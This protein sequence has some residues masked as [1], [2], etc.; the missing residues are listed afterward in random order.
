MKY[1]LEIWYGE[2]EVGQEIVLSMC[3]GDNL[4][5]AIRQANKL[6]GI[7]LAGHGG[8]IVVSKKTKNEQGFIDS[9]ELLEL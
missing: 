5:S 3:F 1:Y 6:A 9:E 7:M 8:S 2:K 4:E